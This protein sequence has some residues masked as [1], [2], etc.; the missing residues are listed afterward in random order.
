MR[1]PS[2]QKA[3][4]S[5]ITMSLQRAELY[6]F[7]A[8]DVFFELLKRR[9]CY[10]TKKVQVE[11]QTECELVTNGRSSMRVIRSKLRKRDESSGVNRSTNV[12]PEGVLQAPV[13]DPKLPHPPPSLESIFISSAPDAGSIPFSP[14]DTSL[15][16]CAS[17]ESTLDS[18]YSVPMFLYSTGNSRNSLNSC[19]QVCC[20][21]FSFST[22]CNLTWTIST[23]T[24]LSLFPPSWPYLPLPPKP[25]ERIAFFLLGSLFR[26]RALSQT[27]FTLQ[28][29]AQ[30]FVL[31]HYY[32]YCV[33]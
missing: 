4:E 8:V 7:S 28:K 16:S 27:I 31:L 26:A 14:S 24:P 25:C 13:G 12:H 21:F 29:K 30:L 20:V 33:T 32:T 18:T 9:I 6:H 1:V 15:S 17:T 5:T 23:G 19:E 22:N 11:N 2:L 3:L 10:Y